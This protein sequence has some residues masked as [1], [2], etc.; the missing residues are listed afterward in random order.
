MLPKLC[1]ESSQILHSDKDQQI[2]FVGGPNTRMTN[3]RWQMVAPSPTYCQLQ[4]YVTQTRTKNPAP[5]S[6]RY[7]ALIYESVVI[8]QPAIINGGG[9]SLRKWSN[10]RLSRARDL[11]LGSGHTAY[12]HAS[13][14][15]LY[16][17]AKFHWDRKI[18]L[19]RITT[20]VTANFKVTWHKN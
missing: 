9:D 8:C 15:D 19:S 4:S 10:F 3:P 18:F 14:I 2:L 17:H 12:R 20:I 6:V 16:L 11:D 1:T 7:C 5:I 13:L